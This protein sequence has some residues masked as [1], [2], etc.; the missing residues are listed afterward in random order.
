MV[1]EFNVKYASFRENQVILS[2]RWLEYLSY[3][4]RVIEK[5]SVVE[6]YN[7][8]FMILSK[9]NIKDIENVFS[10]LQEF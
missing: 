3:T 10:D 9:E 1:Y 2:S 7:T 8:I 4:S 5:K 6:L